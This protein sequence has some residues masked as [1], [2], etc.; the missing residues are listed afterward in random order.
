V[1]PRLGVP[2]DI[3]RLERGSSDRSTLRVRTT[4]IDPSVV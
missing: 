1:S 3:L 4:A 2:D